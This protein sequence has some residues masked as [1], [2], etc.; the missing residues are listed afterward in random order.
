MSVAEKVRN[1][2]KNLPSGSVIAS[3]ELHHLSEDNKQVDKAVS[4]LFRDEGLHK[5]RNGLYYKPVN[6]KYFGTLPP[7]DSAILKAVRKQYEARIVPSGSLA[8]Y[9]LGFTDEAPDEK[10]Y[11]TNKRIAPI[12]TDNNRIIFRQALSKK[13][14]SAN[15]KLVTLLAALEFIFTKYP[16]LNYLQRQLIKRQLDKHPHKNIEKALARWPKWFREKTLSFLKPEK[17][18]K[19]ITGISAFNV[20]YQGR[21]SDWH[22]IGMIAANK[23]QI[24]GDNYHSAP[25]LL[26][27]ELFNCEEFLNTHD[28]DLPSNMCA[29]PA[30]AIKDI[31][32]SNIIKKDEFPHFFNL[33]DYMLTISP[34]EIIDCVNELKPFANESQ[35]DLL[36]LWLSKNDIQ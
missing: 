35:I 14:V 6:S 30:R 23:F 10:T 2:F 12:V 33:D 3:A 25:N 17:A 28:V 8:A 22:Q 31:L 34:K 26:V 32:Y 1:E 36:Y 27:G 16:D 7:K 11:D 15:L 13:L 9:E 5:L 20:P 21:L 4:R 24:A 29:K 19:Y 18:A